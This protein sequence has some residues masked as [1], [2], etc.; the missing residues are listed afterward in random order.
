MPF[1]EG[2]SL[3]ARLEQE[4]QLPLADALRIGREVADALDY[5]HRRNVVHRDI[6][7]ENILLQD[8]HAAVA[9]FGIARAITSAGDDRLTYPGLAVGTPAYMSPEQAIAEEEVDGR[10]D[11][12]SLGCVIY[13]MLAGEPPYTGPTAHAVIAKRFR[14]P[15]PLVGTL[16]DVPEDIERAVARALA[17]APVDRF[18]TAAEFAA[19]L[20]LQ[21]DAAPAR[22]A[23]AEQSIA[24]LPFTNLSPDPENEYFSDGITE[25]VINTLAQL[26]DL[27]VAS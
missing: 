23:A 9:D 18:R 17:P 10:S 8:G 2:A 5:A 15:V 27:R 7:P 14:E 25:E 22:H 1:L 11:I 21:P 6:K 20:E 16:R 19:A 24:V 3:R 26:G 4:A 12:Y 13:E